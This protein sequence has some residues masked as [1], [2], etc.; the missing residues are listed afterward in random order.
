MEITGIERKVPRLEEDIEDKVE[1]CRRIAVKVDQY[2]D[3]VGENQA[4]FQ[5]IIEEIKT[6]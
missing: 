6:Q 1:E 2:R 5:I 3:I 4:N